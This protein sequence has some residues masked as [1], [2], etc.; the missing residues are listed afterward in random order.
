M[1]RTVPN[2]AARIDSSAESMLFRISQ[3]ASPRVLNLAM[4]GKREEDRGRA[5]EEICSWG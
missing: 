1:K 4:Y 2:V 3:R 5:L